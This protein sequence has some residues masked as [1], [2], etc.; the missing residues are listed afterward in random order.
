MIKILSAIAVVVVTI[1]AIDLL[2]GNDAS[3]GSS[4]AST[5][6]A[7]LPAKE[8]KTSPRTYLL[9]T[10]QWCHLHRQTCHWN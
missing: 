9:R 2:A 8:G 4:Q 10:W 5:R 7:Q 3:T 6:H 1:A